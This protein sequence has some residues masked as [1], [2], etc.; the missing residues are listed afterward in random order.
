MPPL[1]SLSVLVALLPLAVSGCDDDFLPFM[2]GTYQ[3]V[4][5]EGAS[6]P[7][8]IWDT[9]A[10]DVTLLDERLI[11]Q[12]DGTVERRTLRRF[13]EGV[14]V[15]EREEWVVMEQEYR[16]EGRTI[17]VGWFNPCPPNALCIA[18]DSGR[19]SR[20][21]VILSSMLHSDD[22]TGVTLEYRRE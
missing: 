22:A 6:L 11:F 21:R 5:A 18:N 16:L 19:A 14:P 13:R 20:E 2:E 10:E 12:S 15:Q 8:T 9:G 1:R 4:R 17:T 3:L 7:F